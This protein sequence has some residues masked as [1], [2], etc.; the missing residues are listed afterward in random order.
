MRKIALSLPGG[1][2]SGALYQV[3]A[4]A[5]LEDGI[6]GLSD[7][8]SFV[9]HASGAIVAAC[10]AGGIS[11]N[12]LY[13]ALL[14][15]ADPFFP[16]ERHHVM[17][18]DAAEWQR[19]MKSVYLAVRHA[20]PRLDPRTTTPI[21]VSFIERF[22]EELDRIEDTLPAGI[23]TL[24]RFERVLAEF[25]ARRDIPNV[26]SRMPRPLRIV[27]HDLDA[28]D[29][30]VFGRPGF[31]EVPVSLACAAS[32]ALPLFFTPVRIGE[33]HYIDG[34][35]CSMTHFDAGVESGAE[36][37]I[38]VNPRVPVSTRGAGVPTGHGVGRS[39]RDKGALWV[40][41]QSRRIASH[42][43][44]GREM[45]HVP[46][47]MTVLRLEPHPED[48]VLFLRN[49]RSFEAR[50]VVLE[51]AYRSTRERL[52]TWLAAHPGIQARLR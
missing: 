10:L 30:V 44:I 51:H 14:D 6:E 20:L 42:S 49:T 13:R 46:S 25:F 21:P 35:L 5:A 9:G 4:L 45:D 36:L 15:P 34:G 7:F 22:I 39:V 38:V 48:A 29:R 12:R 31:A 16:L 26:F 27:A 32:C 41:N 43:M 40:W 50:R 37:M 47:G 19:M 52:A 1:G 18:V 24:D 28:G 8:S 33:R 17:S 23:F 11:A 2:V 3:G